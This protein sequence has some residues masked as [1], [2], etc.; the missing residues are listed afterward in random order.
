[1]E[2]TCNKEVVVR[3]GVIN[4]IGESIILGETKIL[5]V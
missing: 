2:R 4:E 5:N 1:M 3:K